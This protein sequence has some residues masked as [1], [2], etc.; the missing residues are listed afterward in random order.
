MHFFSEKVGH[1]GVS[2]SINTSHLSTIDSGVYHK[3]VRNEGSLGFVDLLTLLLFVKLQG[4]GLVVMSQVS[5]VENPE[6]R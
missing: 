3:E 5:A 2:F 4:L 6:V 1:V